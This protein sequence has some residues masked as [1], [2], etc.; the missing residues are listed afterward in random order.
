M[1][2]SNLLKSTTLVATLWIGCL[3]LAMGVGRDSEELPREKAH[4]F[5]NECEEIEVKIDITHTTDNQ[6]TG[7]IV[8]NFKKVNASY[9]SYVFSG[10]DQNNRL[11]VKDNV[12]SGLEKGEYNL[13]I[14][15]KNGC[16][17]HIKFKI[18]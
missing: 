14:Q 7:K 3:S 15:E 17:K 6:R 2:Y 9:T 1:T 18:N 8:M 10:K 13:Y 16:T 4:Q 11:E 12:I 5:L